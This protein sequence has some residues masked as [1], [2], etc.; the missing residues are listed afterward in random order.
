MVDSGSTTC[1]VDSEFI[2]RHQIPTV[3]KARAESLHV[4]DG[5][6]TAA[7]KVTHQVPLSLSFPNYSET[8]VFQITKL[9]GYHII[10]GKCWLDAHNPEISWPSNTLKI[11]VTSTADGNAVAASDSSSSSSSVSTASTDSG[12]SFDFSYTKNDKNIASTAGSQIEGSAPASATSPLPSFIAQSSA[13]SCSCVTVSSQA[14]HRFAKAEKLQ[15]YRVTAQEVLDY[16]NQEDLTPEQE[17]ARLLE[18]IPKKYHDLLPLFSR[19]G[20][21]QLPPHRDIDHAINFVPD[22]KYPKAPLYDMTPLEL[23]AVKKYLDGMLA[24]GFISSSSSP[25]ASPILFARKPG[26]LRFC[27]DFRAVNDITIKDVTPLPRINES[28]RT[29]AT[30]NIFTKLD[31]RAAYHLIRIKKGDEYKTAFRT[32]YGIFEYNVMPFGLTNAPATCQ[33][34]VSEV[35]SEYLDIFCVC[36]LDD[37][38]VF[39]LNQEEHD[40]HVRKVLL[41]L[42]Q[43]SLFVKGEK[44]EFDKTETTFVGFVISADALKMDPAKVAAVREWEAPRTVKGVQSFLGF[45]NFYRRFIRD[46]SRICTPLFELTKKTQSFVWSSEC[47]AA[48]H[49][50][51]DLF[52]SE[53]ILK[54][55]DYLLDTVIETDASDRVISAV[56]SQY[57]PTD[58]GLLLHPVAYFSQKMNPA[59]CNYGVGDK[60]L[61]AIVESLKSW[62]FMVESLEKPVLV[63]TD[64]RNLAVL[65]QIPAMNRRQARWAMELSEY[66]YVITYR[67]GSLNSRADALTRRYEDLVSSSSEEDKELCAPIIP[68]ENFIGTMS[69]VDEVKIALSTDKWALDVISALRGQSTKPPD[70]DLSVCRLDNDGLLFVNDLLYLPNED[71]RVR[72][73][74]NCHDIMPS[75]HPGQKNTFEL[76]VREYWWPGM[77]R[78]VIR[79]IR[80]C[81]VCQR[82]KSARHSPYGLLKPLTIPQARWTSVSLDFITG[83]PVSNSFDMILVVVDR[84]SKMA[85]FIPCDSSLDAAGF[86]KLY[87]SAVYRLHGLPLDIVS[88]RGSLFTSAF[89]KA[90]AKL[91]GIKQNLST[92]FHPQTDGQTERVNSIL[93]QYLRGYTNYRQDNWAD[94]LPLAEFS[95]NDSESSSTMLTPF[96]ANHGFHPRSG[97]ESLPVS[98]EKGPLRNFVKELDNICQ[99]LKTEITW[100][101]ERMTEYANRHK[102]SAPLLREGDLVWLLSRNIRTTRPSKKLDFKK[103][104]PFK[105]LRKVSSHAYELALPATM[106]V[107]PVFHVCLLEPFLFVRKPGGGLRFCVDY[108]GI[109]AIT[110]KDRYPLPLIS[111]TLRSLAKARYF[112]KVDVR[113]AFHKIRVKEGDEWKTAFRTRFGLYEWLVTPFGLTG[114]PATFQR[115]IN[116]TLRE[117]LDDFCSAYLDDVLIYTD[118]SR[119]EHMEKVELVLKKLGD[120]GLCL[121][122]NKCEFAVTETKY[123]GFIIQAGQGVKVDPAKVAA[124]REWVPPTNVKGVRS[125]IGFANFYRQ[126]ID[127]F[128][129][130]AAPLVSLT[131]KGVPWKWGQ[132][133]ERAFETLKNLFITAPVL[134]MWDEDR[135]TV[136]ECDCSGWAL[137]GTLS[138]VDDDGKLRPV[139]FFSKKLSPA[140]VNYEIHDKELLAVV[141]CL[142]EWRG[143]LK[144]LGAP[145]KILSDHKNLQYFMTTRK[146]SERQVRWSQMLSEFDFKLEF[147]SGS[148]SGKPD[149]LSRRQQDVPQ[150]EDDD[151]LKS[152][153]MKLI[154]DQWIP[155]TAT[156]PVAAG[157]IAESPDNVPDG[158]RLFVQPHLQELWDQAKDHDSDM[159]EMYQAL[160]AGERSFPPSLTKKITI[161]IAECE[162]DQRGALLYRHKLC[163]PEWEPLRTALIQKTHDSHITGH[164]GRDGTL[165]ILSREFFWPGISRDVRRFCANCNVCGR[166][167]VWRERKKGLLLPLPI[168]Q[169]P[170]SELGIDFMTELPAKKSGDPRYLMVIVDRLTGGV[171]LEAMNTM[172]AEECAERFLQCYWKHHG[173]PRAL[174]SDRGTNWTSEF[175]THLCKLT[176]IEQRLS[177]GFHPQTDGATERM[178]QEVLTYLR[179]FITYSQYDWPDLLPSAMLAINNRNTSMGMSPFFLTHGYH[180]SPIEQFTAEESVPRRLE[181]RDAEKFIQRLHEGWELAQAAM[182]ARQQDMEDQANR[183]R[184]PQVRF[185]VGDTVWLKL[186]NISTPQL[187]KKLSWTNAMYKVRKIVSPHV[188][189]LDVPTNV[190]PR[191]HVD[192]LKPASQNPFPSQETDD[193][194]PPPIEENEY[195]EP[196]YLVERILRSRQRRVGRGYRRE[197]LVK[198]A[199]YAEPDWRPRVDFEDTEALEM[200]EA[201]FGTEDDV[202]V[203]EADARTGPRTRTRGGG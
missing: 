57:H 135:T 148:K 49:T 96:F 24:K 60:E 12:A 175:W 189:E 69:L 199:G 19:E 134:A 27:V 38:L 71:L 121:D 99:F 3:L 29:A 93:E 65:K 85:H 129:E 97:R 33:K 2:A 52:C 123:L 172:K 187:S 80:N 197:V 30:G 184:G 131:K 62:R 193:T 21:D 188:V 43:A 178:N 158:S 167:K 84:L 88:D 98:V 130:V 169:R 7:G 141:K 35:L 15:I 81:E 125:F 147:R 202:G 153:I 76:L 119:K 115:Y 146:L 106:K 34:Y 180:V 25:L 73:L 112:T 190:H 157:D 117:H 10:L 23:Q 183:S 48:F 162:F 74:K 17:H 108:R 152:R 120:A 5:S 56:M 137:G 102:S 154:K 166:S 185:E 155:H 9:G 145:F 122:L 118:G 47:E 51:K 171:A 198:W 45:A 55:F 103:L 70:V 164:P 92:A 44:C 179:S 136:V 86:A 58:K 59:Q 194:Q 163:I 150:G 41:K 32:R 28:L 151:R 6:E 126:F 64:H 13:V 111:E 203:P 54:H 11:S 113:A 14:L 100:S 200:F 61:L 18:R 116:S 66:R 87:L 105:I 196:E 143:E 174:V 39:S 138:Q 124:I 104:G 40:V 68:P 140:E 67:P 22:A 128:S 77:R 90:L 191:F 156:V 192:L 89:S 165:A 195:G 133:E 181:H 4:V 109:N 173:F 139:A 201:E 177:T 42:A 83:L 94:L 8:L 142:E 101:R 53:P 186:K 107:H 50:L 31:L 127:S 95:Y 36:Y 16:L 159:Q 78:D 91:L 26:S 170:H 46:F 72:A 114:A 63:L 20:A 160:A 37:I 110:E 161:S 79:Y 75:G 149:A 144:S 182:A 176:G 132:A 82:I 168:P 1:F